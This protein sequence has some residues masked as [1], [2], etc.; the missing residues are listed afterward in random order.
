VAIALGAIAVES[1][2]VAR[3]S[4]VRSPTLRWAPGVAFLISLSV[5]LAMCLRAVRAKRAKA[6]LQADTLAESRAQAKTMFLQTVLIELRTPLQT[7]FTTVESLA[8]QPQ[9]AATATLVERLEGCLA[10]IEDCLDGIAPASEVAGERISG[11]RAPQ[12]SVSH[13]DRLS[14]HAPK[15][16]VTE[17]PK[18]RVGCHRA[19]HFRQAAPSSSR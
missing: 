18:R 2:V 8:L 12:S 6:P 17:G 16:R 7:M 4:C 15:M 11:R 10:Q 19:R 1:I 5:G 3:S 9:S 13:L 14:G